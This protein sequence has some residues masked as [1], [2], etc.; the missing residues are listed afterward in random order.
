MSM[1]TLKDILDNQSYL[2]KS[3]P[4]FACE[5]FYKHNMVYTAIDSGM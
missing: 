1:P 4:C 3:V 2:Q 5:V